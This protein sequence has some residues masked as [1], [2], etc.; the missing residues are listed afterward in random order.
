[1]MNMAIPKIVPPT[2]LSFAAAILWAMILLMGTTTLQP[3]MGLLR[4]GGNPP[5]KRG[6]MAPTTSTA[7]AASAAAAAAAAATSAASST[8]HRALGVHGG[9]GGISLEDDDVENGED[10]DDDDDSDDAGTFPPVEEIGEPSGSNDGS[11]LERICGLY[12]DFGWSAGFTP[13]GGAGGMKNNNNNNNNSNSN[14]SLVACLDYANLLHLMC[15]ND[16]EVS[17]ICAATA[18][19]PPTTT[20]LSDAVH[21][22]FCRPTFEDAY[23]SLVL[24]KNETMICENLCADFI[25]EGSCCTMECP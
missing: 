11:L 14:K 4:H 22:E 25:M 18:M 23:F 10:D 20:T 21:Q 7:T 12:A 2:T 6:I 5:N 13:G 16:Y 15:P 3:C 8:T 9:K 19:T 17:K 1:M 24:N